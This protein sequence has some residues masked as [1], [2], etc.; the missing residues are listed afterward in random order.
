MIAMP[1]LLV[2]NVPRSLMR[3][4][5][6]LKVELGCRI[7]AELLV[8][9]RAEEVIVFGKK[10]IEGMKEAIDDFLELREIVTSRWVREQF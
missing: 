7:C 9:I 6:R 1:T 5:E 2:K 3:E 4:L 10:D 8:R